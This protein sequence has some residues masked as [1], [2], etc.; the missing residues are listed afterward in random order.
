MYGSL[1]LT[2]DVMI[3]AVLTYTT[4]YSSNESESGYDN[5][6]L[7]E[8]GLDWLGRKHGGTARSAVYGIGDLSKK[9]VRWVHECERECEG[10]TRRNSCRK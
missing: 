10:G 3:Q 2:K 1:A 4:I 8:V 9:V 7:S 5:R 6:K